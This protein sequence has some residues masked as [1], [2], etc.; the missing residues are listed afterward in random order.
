MTN[1][2][3]SVKLSGLLGQRPVTMEN[4]IVLCGLGTVG[5]RVAEGLVARG[6]HIAV[7]ESSEANRFLPLIRTHR[8]QVQLV[9]ADARLRDSLS[10][11]NVMAARCIITATNDDMANIQAALNARQLNPGIRVVF[12]MFDQSAAQRV[13]ET[14]GFQVALSASALAAPTFVAAACGQAVVQDF[15]SAPGGWRWRR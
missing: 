11:M 14:F 4:H 10:L 6:E 3:V 12:R 8:E 13:A 15:P 2:I 9:I 7:L 5:Y 1:Y